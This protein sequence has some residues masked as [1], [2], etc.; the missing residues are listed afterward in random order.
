L[1]DET[2]S[3]RAQANEHWQ[4]NHGSDVGQRSQTAGQASRN[5]S[6]HQH[7]QQQ[8]ESKQAK[9]NERADIIYN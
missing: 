9:E 2:E 6:D 8:A 1:P 5:P 3:K 4:Q 7:S